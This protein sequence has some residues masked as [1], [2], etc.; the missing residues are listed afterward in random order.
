LRIG[1][2]GGCRQFGFQSLDEV[3]KGLFAPVDHKNR[4]PLGDTAA[5][6]GGEGI[7]SAFGHG[8]AHAL[9]AVAGRIL[10]TDAQQ[11]AR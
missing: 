4:S 11:I 5:S 2:R 8:S 1:R 7:P 6:G 10:I 3:F 9:D